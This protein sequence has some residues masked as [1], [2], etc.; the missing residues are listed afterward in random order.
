MHFANLEVLMIQP[1]PEPAVGGPG[2][3]FYMQYLAAF[4][5]LHRASTWS[6]ALVPPWRHPRSVYE[7][8]DEASW[9][10]LDR[11]DGGEGC[12]KAEEKWF[13][14][15]VTRGQCASAWMRTF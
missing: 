10:W 11:L 9:D 1:S 14:P 6:W 15:R 12:W 3:G 8:G 7:E 2:V 13:F 4:N 5:R